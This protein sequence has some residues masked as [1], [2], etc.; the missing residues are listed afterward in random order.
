[1]KTNPYIFS[2]LPLSLT[3]FACGSDKGKEQ[4]SRPDL[5]EEVRPVAEAIENESPERF[6][7]SV[8]Y[9]I[10]RP[11]PLPDVKDSAEMVKYYDK[12]IDAPLKQAVKEQ[13]DSAWQQE[14]WRGWTLENG[15]YFWIDAGKIY[16]ITYISKK[17]TQMLDSLQNLEISSLEP[18]MRKDWIPVACV[19]DSVSGA[20]FRIDSRHDSDPP[21]YRLAGYSAEDDLSGEPTIMLYGTLDLE[22][23]MGNRYYRFS[24]DQGTTAEYA[25]DISEEEDTPQIEIDR[26]GK[27]KRYKAKPAYWLDHI[28]KNRPPK[29][30]E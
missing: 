3:L 19:T 14:G 13:P 16:E 2:L 5:P 15:A 6:A 22:G 17:E 4:I 25:P 26:K 9:P 1:M 20:I 29:P 7:S 10:E 18:S 23:S 11:Y 21:V 27:A 30:T 24:D 28:K 12:M 8:T